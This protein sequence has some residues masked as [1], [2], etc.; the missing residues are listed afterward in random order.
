MFGVEVG[1]RFGQLAMSWFRRGFVCFR[2][3]G[4]F[5]GGTFSGVLV[6][7]WGPLWVFS[8]FFAHP[9]A[10]TSQNFS[11]KSTF[12]LLFQFDAL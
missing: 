4:G 12:N 5:R 9:N 10:Q 8:A 7:F 3:S 6:F 2:T 1:F 11:E